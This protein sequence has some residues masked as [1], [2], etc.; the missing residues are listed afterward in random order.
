M[1]SVSELPE[2]FIYIIGSYGEILKSY[3][4]EIEGQLS[5]IVTDGLPSYLWPEGSRIIHKP[6]AKQKIMV[7]QMFYPPLGPVEN[8]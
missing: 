5:V 7:K 3:N 4:Y 2:G 8:V 1:R 6:T